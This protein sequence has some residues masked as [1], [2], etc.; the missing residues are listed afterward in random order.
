M[1]VGWQNELRISRAFYDSKHAIVLPGLKPYYWCFQ[2]EQVAKIVLMKRVLITN[3]YNPGGLIHELLKAGWLQDQESRTY[4][5]SYGS[6]RIELGNLERYFDL[7][8]W[9]YYD[10]ST[11]MRQIEKSVEMVREKAKDG[12]TV[13][14]EIHI[15]QM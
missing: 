12:K 8:N 4:R 1:N 13:R 10:V 14:A 11:I 15:R 3:V 7:N 2:D 6:S 9:Y 5:R